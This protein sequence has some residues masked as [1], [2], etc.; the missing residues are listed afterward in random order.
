MCRGEQAGLGAEHVCTCV[1]ATSFLL[2][3]C[4]SRFT[5][6][7]CPLGTQ[8]RLEARK[9]VADQNSTLQKSEEFP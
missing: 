3:G 8:Q 4:Y 5:A 7:P 9:V 2:S 6:F 1:R